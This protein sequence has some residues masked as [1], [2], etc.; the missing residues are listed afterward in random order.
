MTF[1]IDFSSSFR[2]AG[3]PL[4]LFR[5]SS[6]HN[7]AFSMTFSVRREAIPT[8]PPHLIFDAAIDPIDAKGIKLPD[9]E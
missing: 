5:H 2:K 9:F 6:N 8:I 3:I 1:R 4:P 7:V